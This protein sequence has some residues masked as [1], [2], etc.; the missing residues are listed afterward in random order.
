MGE[1]ASVG[2]HQAVAAV[3]GGSVE[4]TDAA[5]QLGEE[6]GDRDGSGQHQVD[7]T[8]AGGDGTRTSPD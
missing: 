7:A 1:V 6:L 4:K 2:G 8:R 3:D 5:R